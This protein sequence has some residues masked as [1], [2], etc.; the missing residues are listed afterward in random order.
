MERAADVEPPPALVNRIL[1]EQRWK[2]QAS[3]SAGVR[4]WIRRITAAGIAA[5][6]RHEH[7]D[8]DSF[9]GLAGEIRGAGAAD[10]GG[11]FQSGARLAVGGRSRRI[12]A[13]SAR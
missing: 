7:G 3:R 1:F 10:D 13:G 11:G 6:I 8:H 12:A 2:Q 4:G 9:A 5:E